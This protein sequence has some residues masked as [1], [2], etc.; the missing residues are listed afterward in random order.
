ME[1]NGLDNI[2]GIGRTSFT[3][4]FDA[5]SWMSNDIFGKDLP[6]QIRVVGMYRPT[7]WEKFKAWFGYEY[8]LYIAKRVEPRDLTWVEKKEIEYTKDWNKKFQDVMQQYPLTPNEVFLHPVTG[9]DIRVVD[10]MYHDDEGILPGFKPLT[11]D[12]I[13]S[14]SEGMGLMITDNQGSFSLLGDNI[15]TLYKG[16]S[17]SLGDLQ[18]ILLDSMLFKEGDVL[19]MDGGKEVMILSSAQAWVGYWL[20]QTNVNI[21]IE[22]NEILVLKSKV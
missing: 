12:D 22:V 1:D 11:K 19:V 21:N 15:Q 17:A 13:S 18:H 8:P 14:V 6:T 7:W 3:I 10:K 4:R 9:A 20:Y 5:K 2:P 16:R